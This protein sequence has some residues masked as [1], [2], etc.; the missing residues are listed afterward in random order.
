M[1]LAHVISTRLTS[2]RASFQR[3]R[4]LASCSIAP[5]PYAGKPQMRP[6]GQ[7]TWDTGTFMSC[8]RVSPAGCPRECQPKRERRVP[9]WV[10]GSI[11]PGGSSPWDNAGRG[12]IRRH[13]G[14]T[15]SFSGGWDLVFQKPV[16]LLQSPSQPTSAS[17]SNLASSRV[18]ATGVGFSRSTGSGLKLL[19]G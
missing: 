19:R 11:P 16:V 14:S 8:R 12:R 4:V 5:T 17:R 2:A 18:R 6:G 3:I 1:S 15:S 7:G 13:N 10:D 9:R